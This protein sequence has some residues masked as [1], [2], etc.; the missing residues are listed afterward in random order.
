MSVDVSAIFPLELSSLGVQSSWRTSVVE[1]GGGNEQRAV[2]WS[3]ARRRYDASTPTLTLVQ[4]R[5]IESHHN[6]R[7][8]QGRA[9]PVRDRSAWRATG[10]ALGT[11]GGIAST[12][13]LT[14][15]SGDASNAYG[16]E[17]YL[18]Q[19]GT[20]HIYA[21]AVEKAE[22]TDWTMAYSG[23]TAG[24]LTWVTNQTGAT[25]TAD[26]DYYVPVRYLQDE[27]PGAELFIWDSTTNLGLVR[28]PSIPLIEVRWAGEFA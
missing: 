1:L 19:S 17:I 4:Y 2:L 25:I 27:L 18:P 12:M 5:Q 21:N 7:R 13:Q 8:G 23:A 15:A 16:R 26:F 14:V 11:A 20:V 24:T 10:Q 6:G 28:G 22:T 3:D 9:F